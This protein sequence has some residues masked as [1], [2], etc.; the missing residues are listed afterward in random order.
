MSVFSHRFCFKIGTIL[1]KETIWK[2]MENNWTISS[3]QRQHYDQNLWV[4]KVCAGGEGWGRERDRNRKKA[5]TLKS[6][7]YKPDFLNG[8]GSTGHGCQTLWYPLHFC[9]EVT[10]QRW[11]F[12][13]LSVW[14]FRMCLYD[15]TILAMFIQCFSFSQKEYFS[16]ALQFTQ[17]SCPLLHTILT[18]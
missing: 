12:S 7:S 8:C 16:F 3:P 1:V 14:I 13:Y 9:Q 17:C 11:I 5:C 6:P 10:E 15:T 18:S 2:A 4:V